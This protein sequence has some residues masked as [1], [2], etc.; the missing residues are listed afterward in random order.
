[1]KKGETQRI[2][3]ADFETTVYEGQQRT[4]VWAAASVELFTEDVVIH[5]SIAEQ[6]SYF[7]QS[8]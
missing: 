8:K 7:R 5:H 3:M 4:E 1:M 2:E 6:F